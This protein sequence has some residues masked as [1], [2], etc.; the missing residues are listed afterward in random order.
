MPIARWSIRATGH[1]GSSRARTWRISSSSRLMTMHFYI[2]RRCS[3]APS[4]LRGVSPRGRRAA[5]HRDEHAP[6]ETLWKRE[7]TP[8]M[9]AV[10][11][12]AIEL[13]PRT[14]RRD[15]PTRDITPLHS[16]TSSARANNHRGTGAADWTTSHR[17]RTPY[18]GTD[19]ADT[20]RQVLTPGL[21][22]ARTWQRYSFVGYRSRTSD[23]H[24]ADIGR[25][26]HYCSEVIEIR[27]I[28]R[29]IASSAGEP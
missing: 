3:R 20:I 29:M 26:Q 24:T 7:H 21:G 1:A 9:S 15:V 18:Q 10:P 13:V 25:G 12:I 5:E 19:W 28:A 23:C 11:P 17:S 4:L 27:P 8:T 14:Q 16:I 6:N 22:I 2:K